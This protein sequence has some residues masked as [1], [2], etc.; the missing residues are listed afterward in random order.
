MQFGKRLRDERKKNNLSAEKLAEDCEVSRSYITLI[1]SHKRLPS[2][3]VLPRI[4]MA[5]N[6][7]TNV[8]INWYLEDVRVKLQE[9]IATE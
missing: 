3:K 2:P 6:L 5:L 7:K 1:E 4:A 8:V 9:S